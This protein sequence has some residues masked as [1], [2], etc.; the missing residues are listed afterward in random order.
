MDRYR[1]RTR[2]ARVCALSQGITLSPVTTTE[3]N[4][5]VVVENLKNVIVFCYP[6]HSS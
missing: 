3:H 4:N 1:A 2:L 6:C 5:L